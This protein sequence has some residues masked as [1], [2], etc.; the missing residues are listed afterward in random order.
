[1]GAVLV[2][3]SVI[4]NQSTI[5]VSLSADAKDYCQSEYFNVT[6]TGNDVIL[7]EHAQYGRMRAGRCVSGSYGVL[8]CSVDVLSYFDRLC[9]GRHQCTVYIG[10][11]ALH[12]LEPCSKDFTTYLEAIQ[13]CLE[14]S[15]WPKGQLSLNVK[16]LT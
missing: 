6:C 15:R 2:T 14:G 8:G 12:R 10:D 1:M 4:R 11:P 16:I 3:H 9:S 7:M 5:F 13:H